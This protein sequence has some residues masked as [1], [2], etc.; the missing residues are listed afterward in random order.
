MWL[1][2]RNSDNAVI[3]TQQRE[4]PSVHWNVALF[5]VKEWFGPEPPLHDPDEGVVSLD[6]TLT[7]PDYATFTEARTIFNDLEAQA[8]T[9]ILWLETAIP[10]IDTADLA[11]LRTV[12]KR[13]A[14]EN[15]R[16]VK[17]WRYL[18][19]RVG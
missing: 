10:L 6:P 11:D 15:L 4:D 2:I 12:V 3:G 13:L 18:F 17:A 1:I 8:V 5:T 7:D 14:Q 16:E 19:R 9:E